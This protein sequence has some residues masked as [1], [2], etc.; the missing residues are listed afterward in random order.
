LEY[1]WL[2]AISR[3]HWPTRLREKIYIYRGIP[4]TA[5]VSANSR[6][7]CFTKQVVKII[8][9]SDAKARACVSMHLRPIDHTMITVHLGIDSGG[10]Y[11]AG[12]VAELAH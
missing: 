8:N 5:V 1:Y 2:N 11:N 6:S 3:D 7:F 10:A 9:R 4:L 12:F